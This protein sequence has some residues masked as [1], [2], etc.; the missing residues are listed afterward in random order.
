MCWQKADRLTCRCVSHAED[1]QCWQCHCCY[2][3]FLSIHK[4]LCTHTQMSDCCNCCNCWHYCCRLAV[5]MMNYFVATTFSLKFIY[6]Y[7]FQ[8]FSFHITFVFLFSVFFCV[9]HWNFSVACCNAFF[10]NH[11]TLVYR[12][13]LC[14][15]LHT[16]TYMSTCNSTL[17]Q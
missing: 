15:W 7:Y 12:V 11:I 3:Y 17:R 1:L 8:T 4:Q 10:I 9:A 5:T 16:Y 14:N 2:C 13:P 6:F